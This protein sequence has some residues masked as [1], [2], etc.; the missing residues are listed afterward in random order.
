MS[1]IVL[2]IGA[3]CPARRVVLLSSYRT[4]DAAPYALGLDIGN[5]AIKA[6]VLKQTT[7]GYSVCYANRILNAESDTQDG[8]VNTRNLAARL[9]RLL[10]QAGLPLTSAS[11]ALPTEHAQIR[12]IDLPQMTPEAL[13]AATK[14]EARKYLP[15]SVEDAEAQLLAVEQS[16]DLEEGK[17]RALMVAAPRNLIVGRAEALEDA[18]LEVAHA[19]VET[20]PLLRSQ[21]PMERAGS[22]LWGGQPLTHVHLGHVASCMCVARDVDV[23]FMR[24]ISWGSVRLSQALAERLEIEPEA[25]RA[26]LES[27]AAQLDELGALTWNAAGEAQQTDALVGELERLYREIQRLLN[28]YRSLFPER[29]Y[30]GILDRIYL[31]G[32]AAGLHGLEDYFSRALNF[33]VTISN[34]F[35]LVTLQL[36]PESFAA[37]TGHRTEFGIAVGLAMGALEAGRYAEARQG[38]RM[39]EFVWRRKAA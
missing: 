3:G 6:I 21:K 18:G 33:E 35:Q 11:F 8:V 36:S 2:L 4:S 7:Q 27:P 30:E 10:K 26:I 31:S 29:S 1:F 32:G 13:R 12:W 16:G 28:Y 23:R 19:E 5:H 14:F 39:R 17:M 34:P 20:F 24:A 37:V 9:R 38:Q 22:A 25:A 15:Y